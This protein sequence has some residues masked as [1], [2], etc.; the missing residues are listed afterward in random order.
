MDPC[1]TPVETGRRSDRLELIRT[2]SASLS[3]HHV[4]KSG[5]I[6]SV[7]ILFT[8]PVGIEF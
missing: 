3:Q 8:L 1:G 7:M 4:F 5:P 2:L 6:D